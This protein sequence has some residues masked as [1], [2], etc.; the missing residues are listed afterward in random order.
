MCSI[1]VTF[2]ESDPA[3]LRSMAE[4]I[5]HR[6]PD[7]FEILGNSRHGIA[8]C[9][10][11]IFGDSDGPMIYTDPVTGHV[12]LLNGEIYN[13]EDLWRDLAVKGIQRRSNLEA[14][15]IARLY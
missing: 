12:V 10:L 9:R 8:A 6:G 11:S 3:V 14:E 1:I 4:S 5:R 2:N 7:S 15:L 13:Y